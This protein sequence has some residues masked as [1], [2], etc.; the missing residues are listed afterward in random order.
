M[1][2]Q[3]RMNTEWIH[4]WL[5]ASPRMWFD[6]QWHDKQTDSKKVQRKWERIEFFYFSYVFVLKIIICQS[7]LTASVLLMQLIKPTVHLCFGS[8]EHFLQV[9]YQSKSRH[10]GGREKQ[11]PYCHL[12][13]MLNFHSQENNSHIYKKNK[14][15]TWMCTIDPQIYVTA[16]SH[17]HQLKYTP[18]MAR[19]RASGHATRVN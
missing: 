17:N 12:H 10:G 9:C 6:L 3:R 19:D 14:H 11:V 7:N 5:F 15:I 1:E 13:K 8:Y 16:Y 18:V 2:Y 4:G